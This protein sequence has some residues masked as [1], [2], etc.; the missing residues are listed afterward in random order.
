M[1]CRPGPDRLATSDPPA[2]ESQNPELRKTEQF[3][4]RAAQRPTNEFWDWRRSRV[5][6]QIGREASRPGLLLARAERSNACKVVS[7]RKSRK[8]TLRG[9]KPRHK[10]QLLS[11]V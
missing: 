11:T 3:Q 2:S 7:P 6:G 4:R 10:P 9:L 1:R 8:G 5:I